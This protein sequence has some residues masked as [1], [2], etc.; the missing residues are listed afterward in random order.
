MNFTILSLV[1]SVYYQAAGGIVVRGPEAL[2]LRKTARD[3]WV[4]PKGH[5]EAGES[6][7]AAALRETREETGYRHPRIV[8]ALGTLRAEFDLPDRRVTRDES[9]F[10]MELD[11]EARDDD[12]AHAD[13]RADSAAFERHWLP[14]AEAA[15]RL[16]FEPARTF[17]RRAHQQVMSRT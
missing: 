12:P 5:V 3:E 2:V 15:E 4:L 10:L 8:A 11:S 16:S 14:L 7:E 6:L 13:A 9:Y 1:P 17:M